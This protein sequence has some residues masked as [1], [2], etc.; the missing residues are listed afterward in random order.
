MPL[1]MKSYGVHM[2]VYGCVEEHTLV[3]IGPIRVGM[4]E[5]GKVLERV[6]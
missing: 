3:T 2:L 1:Q 4:G 5:Q 6:Q